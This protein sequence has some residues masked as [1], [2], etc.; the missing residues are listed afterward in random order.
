MTDKAVPPVL[1]PRWGPGG[2]AR[3]SDSDAVPIQLTI[4]VDRQTLAYFAGLLRVV[5]PLPDLLAATKVLAGFGLRPWAAG[6]SV[7]VTPRTFRIGASNPSRGL[8]VYG[9]PQRF[10]SFDGMV[11]THELAHIALSRWI[12]S[13]SGESS[14]GPSAMSAV[15]EALALLVEDCALRAVGGIGYESVWAEAELDDFHSYAWAV[16][17][18]SGPVGSLLRTLDRLADA[19]RAIGAPPDR[20][21]SISALLRDREEREGR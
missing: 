1:A 4:T 3:E 9:Q 17:R 15:D 19:A 5:D 12:D 18:R 16:V 13:V 6:C 11:I 7:H 8:I 20:P 2:P 14:G 10:P 21:G